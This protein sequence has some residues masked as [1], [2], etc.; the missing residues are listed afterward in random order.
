MKVTL[1][2][3]ALKEQS[4]RQGTF[5]LS[6][7]FNKRPSWKSKSQAI[8]NIANQWVIGNLEDVGKDES[9]GKLDLGISSQDDNEVDPQD[10]VSWD[11]YNGNDKEWLSPEKIN[12]IIVECIDGTLAIK[13]FGM[14]QKVLSVVTFGLIKRACPTS[15]HFV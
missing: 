9:S 7:T 2:N 5:Q 4:L 11:Y 13:M 6:S 3:K 15:A 10:I 12:D 14:D 8:W 1:K